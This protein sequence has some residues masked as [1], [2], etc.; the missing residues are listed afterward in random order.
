MVSTSN[1]LQLPSLLIPEHNTSGKVI[2]FPK[3]PNIN[4]LD[5]KS[6]R[7]TQLL[8]K[9]SNM[10]T[11]KMEVPIRALLTRLETYDFVMAP[12]PVTILTSRTKCG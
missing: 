3:S 5:S 11:Q 2:M 8:N 7:F 4:F 12:V 9:T 10:N 1:S 6:H